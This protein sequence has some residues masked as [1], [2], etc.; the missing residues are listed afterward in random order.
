MG[1]LLLLLALLA[2]P[3]GESRTVVDPVDGRVWVERWSYARLD[4]DGSYLG[5]YCPTPGP[6][7]SPVVPTPPPEP[8]YQM[9]AYAPLML[10]VADG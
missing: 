9:R 6:R 3:C 5:E 7:P 2:P 4:P 1:R 8:A 10:R